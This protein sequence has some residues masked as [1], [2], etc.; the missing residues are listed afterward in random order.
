MLTEF[1]LAVRREFARS[2]RYR[3]PISLLLLDLPPS[4]EALA[5]VRDSVR[6]C[7]S[8][9]GAPGDRMAV[10]LPETPLE[11]ALLVASRLTGATGPGQPPGGPRAI[12]VAASPAPPVT[13]AEDL[14]QAAGRA[15]ES[16]RSR[17]GGVMTPPHRA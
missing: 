10:I 11:G 14:L 12:G 8:V 4:P 7:D 6:L 13:S 5:E 3:H 1:Q 15:L 17:G 9:L 16:A 2:V